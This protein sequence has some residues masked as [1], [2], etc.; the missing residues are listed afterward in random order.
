MANDAVTFATTGTGWGIL[1]VQS[2]TYGVGTNA[3]TTPA[4][5]QVATAPGMYTTYQWPLT[6][7]YTYYQTIYPSN[8]YIA[9]APPQTYIYGG[10]QERQ[11][12]AIESPEN[13]VISKAEYD[14]LLA[15]KRQRDERISRDIIYAMQQQ[16]QSKKPQTLDIPVVETQKRKLILN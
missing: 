6:N 4:I 14:D 8:P 9:T 13:I 16:Q 7:T 15:A 11:R 12:N 3:V 5:T 10:V 1:D 2:G